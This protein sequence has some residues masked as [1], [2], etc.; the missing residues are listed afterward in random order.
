VIEVLAKG[1]SQ[2]RSRTGPALLVFLETTTF[3]IV[4]EHT[5]PVLRVL[6]CSLD[7]VTP[8]VSFMAFSRRRSICS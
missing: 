7:P 3:F 6:P 8:I 2:F 5:A 1:Y 4:T